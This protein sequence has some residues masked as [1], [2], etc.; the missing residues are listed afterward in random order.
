M[1]EKNQEGFSALR[2]LRAPEN[3]ALRTG[4][5]LFWKKF[6]DYSSSIIQ[7]RA[8]FWSHFGRHAIF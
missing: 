8:W 3:Y 4:R 1:P 7:V 2:T 5:Q 6:H